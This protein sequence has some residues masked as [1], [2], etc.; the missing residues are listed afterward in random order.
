MKKCEC[1]CGNPAPIARQTDKSR[2]YVKGQPRRFVHNHWKHTLE[3]RRKISKIHKGNTYGLTHGHAGGVN[4]HRSS[5]YQTWKG[6]KYRCN[7]PNTDGYHNYGGRGISVCDGWNDSF[8]A[9]LADMGERPDG[10]TIDRIDNDGNY[11]P[12]NCRWATRKQQA[13]N[14]RL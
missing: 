10:M 1:G 4:K 12:G 6:M 2:G 14:R 11:E 7:N 9:F 3:T 5:T 8:E 13:N